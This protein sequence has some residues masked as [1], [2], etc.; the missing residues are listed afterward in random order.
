MTKNYRNSLPQELWR[1][2]VCRQAVCKLS[3]ASVETQPVPLSSLAVVVTVL[4]V[5]WLVAVKL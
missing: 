3:S 2:S 1:L 5:P 4:G